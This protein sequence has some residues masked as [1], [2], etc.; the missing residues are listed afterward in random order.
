LPTAQENPVWHVV[1]GGFLNYY[2]EYDFFTG[3]DT[4]IDPYHWHSLF[5]ID[6][7][8]APDTI[9]QGFYRV[10][11]P[12]AFIRPYSLL[13]G[14][15]EEYL[16]YDFSAE[17]GDTLILPSIIFSGGLESYPFVVQSVSAIHIGAAE[18]RVI[19]LFAYN[20]N[21][22]SPVSASPLWIEGVGDINHP[23]YFLSCS[24]NGGGDGSCETSS[25]LECLH[26]NA[27]LSYFSLFSTEPNCFEESMQHRFYVDKD[28]AGG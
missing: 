16:L 12:R 5:S 2:N 25:L 19:Q 26:T 22:G 27:G 9:L 11:G 21:I 14:L 10:D 8:G 23:F 6:I 24:S 20:G 4:F 7:E 1:E 17:I 28:A 18:R 3:T 13:A 15:A